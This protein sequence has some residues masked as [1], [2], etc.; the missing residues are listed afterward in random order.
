V[1]LI[2]LRDWGRRG[3][4]KLQENIPNT[5]VSLIRVGDIGKLLSFS[6]RR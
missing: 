6:Y 3:S 1:S 2:A 5:V 4:G